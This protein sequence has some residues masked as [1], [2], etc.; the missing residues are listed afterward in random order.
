MGVKIFGVQTSLSMPG[1]AQI[2]L[3]TRSVKSREKTLAFFGLRPAC[4]AVRRLVC[5][6]RRLLGIFP[7]LKGNREFWTRTHWRMRQSLPNRSL[8]GKFPGIMAQLP[9]AAH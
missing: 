3:Y 6:G 5:E 4:V 2:P 8:L 7:R 1:R 9:Q